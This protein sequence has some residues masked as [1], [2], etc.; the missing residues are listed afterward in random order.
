MKTIIR[1]GLPLLAAAQ[2]WAQTM[3]VHPGFTLTSLRPSGFNPMVSGMD[4]LSDG[5]MVVSTWDPTGSVYIVENV[6]SG[7]SSKI[8]VKTIAQ[9]LAEQVVQGLFGE[10]QAA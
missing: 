9:G 7:D 8:K 5:R 4:F 3:P 2:L 6:E 10:G 1:S